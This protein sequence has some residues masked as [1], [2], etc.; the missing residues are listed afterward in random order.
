MATLTATRRDR[1][2]GRIGAGQADNRAGG[3]RFRAAGLRPGRGRP[4][5]ARDRRGRGGAQ[6]PEPESRTASSSAGSLGA[7]AAEQ[8]RAIVEAAERSASEIE[9]AA[10]EKADRVTGEA[11]RQAEEE[12]SSARGEADRVR[13][14]AEEAASET[15]ERAEA[16]AAA[17]CCLRPGGHG[18]HAVACRRRRDRPDG[19]GGPASHAG[20]EIVES[21]RSNAGSL[22]TELSNIRAGLA[23]VQAAEPE[24]AA[25]V[26]P[27]AEAEP[28]ARGEPPC[29]GGGRGRAEPVAEAELTRD[30]H[31]D[32]DIVQGDEPTEE[33][34]V[35]TD[36]D[37]DLEAEL[38]GRGRGRGGRCSRRRRGD[39]GGRDRR[40]GRARA[41]PAGDESSEGAR[42]IALNMALNG[43]PREETAR[44]LDENFDLE[45]PRRGSSTRCTPGSAAE[46]VWLAAN[47]R[48]SGS[49]VARLPGQASLPASPL[50]LGFRGQ[51][52]LSGKRALVAAIS[53]ARFFRSDRIRTYVRPGGCVD[54]VM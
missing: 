36:L 29:R 19:A 46:P 14:E 51:N 30:R 48:L 39:R 44:Y 18:R 45:D 28:A 54:S 37:D 34:A 15:R 8:V 6:A 38:D 5:P 50:M 23:E 13:R 21:V 33:R 7:A 12:R 9:A 31:P 3:L 52:R 35:E 22:E 32:E 17:A 41:R 24:P 43:T 47:L 42:L 20:R 40:R 4:P 49:S 10:T 11:T 25:E 27:A 1:G 53:L 16:E 26:E 2:S